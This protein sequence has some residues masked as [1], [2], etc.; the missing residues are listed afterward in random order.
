MTDDDFEMCE[1]DQDVRVTVAAEEAVKL[2]EKHAAVEAAGAASVAEVARLLAVAAEEA[3]AA[4][5]AEVDRIAAEEEAAAAVAAGARA[6]IRLHLDYSL[7]KAEGFDSAFE[8]DMAVFLFGN[9]G[10]GSD[11][12]TA[13]G[14]WRVKVESLATTTALDAAKELMLV[15]DDTLRSQQAAADQ[16]KRA[17]ELMEEANGLREKAETGD[18][19]AIEAYDAAM[20]VAGDAKE[21]ARDAAAQVIEAATNLASTQKVA[22]EAKL[23]ALEDA[24]TGN[25]DEFKE[26]IVVRF[27]VYAEPVVE[28]VVFPLSGKDSREEQASVDA[29]QAKLQSGGMPSFSQLSQTLGQAVTCDPPAMT[30]QVELEYDRKLKASEEAHLHLRSCKEAVDV[31]QQELASAEVA[32]ASAAAGLA[33]VQ[34]AEAKKAEVADAS[35]EVAMAAAAAEAL[36]TAKDADELSPEVA[37]AHA[38]ARATEAATEGAKEILAAAHAA[39]DGAQA[40]VDLADKELEE[41]RLAMLAAAADSARRVAEAAAAAEEAARAE[42]VKAEDAAAKL[43][44]KLAAKAEAAEAAEAAEVAELELHSQQE[45]ALYSVAF[46]DDDGNTSESSYCNPDYSDYLG[47]SISHLRDHTEAVTDARA[48]AWAELGEASADAA[49]SRSKAKNDKTASTAAMSSHGGAQAKKPA[50]YDGAK[51]AIT[52]LASAIWQSI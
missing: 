1:N 8:A 48:K 28:P 47:L 11:N 31:A 14:G 51:S 13:Q 40:A 42:Q 3:E 7:A 19:A 23:I 5:A 36:A 2:K 32:Q 24:E 29:V 22:C 17:R 43:A 33:A 21:E 6:S 45:E 35:P 46:T 34:E 44:A 50:K 18:P 4:R 12:T 52:G 25:C 41:A 9:D 30:V 38:V 15:A 26:E 49:S 27:V 39:V 37:A 16:N 20:K 10:D